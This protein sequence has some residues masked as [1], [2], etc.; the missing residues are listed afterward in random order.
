MKRLMMVS[1]MVPILLLGCSQREPSVSSAPAHQEEGGGASEHAHIEGSHGGTMVSIGADDYHAEVVF[2]SGGKVHLFLLGA[3]QRKVIEVDRQT[4]PAFARLEGDREA[5]AIRFE[6][7]P[8]AGDEEGKTSAFVVQLSE[9]LAGR[10]FVVTIPGFRIAGERY[11]VEF[12]SQAE[13]GTD[14][15]IDVPDKVVSDA[16]E[17][18]YLRPGGKYTRAD[19]QANGDV[20]ATVRFAGLRATHDLK[21]KPGDPICP[22]TLTKA[23]RRFSWV[24][25]GQT[26]QFCCPPCVDE[27]VQRAKSHPDEILAPED[28]VAADNP[29]GPVES[30]APLPSRAEETDK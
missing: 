13:D 4:V 1:G 30:P 14:H 3:D 6:P 16:E 18:L 15:E 28:Y 5:S 12:A 17:E 11:R 22:I 26:Y 21:P 8:Q 7:D 29:G 9:D 19:I 24:V 25:G 27:F 23:D 10:E 2:E 20:T